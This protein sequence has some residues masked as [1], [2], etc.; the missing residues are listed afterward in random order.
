MAAADPNPSFPIRPAG[1]EEN[2]TFLRPLGRAAGNS[3]ALKVILGG[4]LRQLRM[5]AGLD[6]ADVDRRLRFSP[7]K[8]SRM[9]LAR[10][11]CKRADGLALLDLYGVENPQHR[12]EFMRLL[13]RSH[14]PDWW[15]SWNDVLTSFFTPL[16]SLE[17]AAE[18]IRTYEPVYVPGLLQTSD[19]ARAVILSESPNAQPHEVERR[20]KLRLERQRQLREPGAS[21]LW[22]I[23]DESV[24]LRP[25]GGRDVMDAQNEYLIECA[26]RSNVV[27]QI[28]SV[29]V[30]REV[31]IGTGVTHLNFALDD[32][33]NAVYVEYLTGAMFSQKPP[34]VERYQVLL[35]KLSACAMTPEESVEWLRGRH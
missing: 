15:K 24:L 30:T 31:S 7:A 5:E 25:V 27:I 32:L 2:Q 9:E 11:G 22:A 21:H 4:K 13:D 8:T 34:D 1:T 6:P 26:Q 33:A 14:Q 12:E 23:I 28:A 35:D 3:T 16:L 19:Y 17:G 18:H 29:D 10:Q 20:V